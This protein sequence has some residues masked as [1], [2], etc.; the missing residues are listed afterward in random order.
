MTEPSHA[1]FLS[2]ASEDQEATQRICEA[3]RS[4]GIEVWF[5]Q[6][7][8]R[9]G[10]AWDAS[11]RRQIKECA[12]FVPVIS[13]HTDARPV[14]YFR[15]EWHLALDRMM[16]YAED[17][18]FLLPVVIDDTVEATA[19][20]PDRFRERQWTYLKGGAA[21]PEWVERTK[22]LLTERASPARRT[23]V[24]PAV[25]GRS[26]WPRALAALSGAAL[27]ALVATTLW[28]QRMGTMTAA[29][30]A[31]VATAA[32]PA[33]DRKTIAV[34]PFDNL[35]GR[36]EDAYL[37][38]GLQAEVLNTLARLRELS[39]ISRTST[40]EYRDKPL[41]VRDIG[42]R[43]GVGTILEGSIRRY[44]GKLR[45]AVQLVD[46]NSDRQLLAAN[47][48]RDVAHMLDLQ[49]AVARQVADSLLA[50]LSRSDRGELERV[51]TNNGDAYDLYLRAMAGYPLDHTDDDYDVR[52]PKRLLEQ[53][54]KLDPGY[55]DAY[56]FL[57]M[58]NTT[59]YFHRRRPEDAVA[60]RRAFE[61]AFE[62][63]PGLP[64]ARL[65]RG[66]YAT[67][68]ALDP[69]Q[70]LD[71]LQAVVRS[72]PSSARA[73]LQLGL[74]LRRLGRMDEAL[75]HFVR[76]WDLDP[77]HQGGSLRVQPLITLLGLRRWP[78][79][80][81][82]TET[83]LRRFPDEA[84]YYLW[85]A[86]IQSFA[87]HDAEPMR[88]ALRDHGNECDAKERAVTGFEVAI[89]EG[90]YL[91]AIRLQEIGW[92]YFPPVYRE[93]YAGVLYHIAGDERRARDS[94]RAAERHARQDSGAREE[95]AISQS[96]LGEHAAALATID[97]ARARTPESR[98]AINGP[99]IS[100]VRSVVLLRAGRSEEAYAEVNRLLRVPFG[101]PL[102]KFGGL[103][104]VALL[105]KDDTHFDE[106]LH[107]PP[108]L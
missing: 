7:E 67:I 95:L 35:S 40:L 89:A 43:L 92:S 59:S 68:V 12:L 34:L 62:I 36:T 73:H 108:R 58:V 91:D 80:I 17:Q 78:E 85:R 94:L 42:N 86:K 64:E 45:L 28:K 103:N 96:V 69:G 49:S 30:V 16:D 31:K 84:S 81:E 106:L 87:Q 8:L 4:A 107:R 65:A 10:D 97:A 76:S 93:T 21:T 44:G 77:L 3:L 22:R 29:P 19:R 26:R 25:P 101:N 56:A 72:R 9:G 83:L 66:M 32:A 14:G 18:P 100:F 105:V 55:A 48:D 61:R 63:D 15:R 88:A 1:V 41:N 90:R 20:V 70:A 54:V 27:A 33:R 6:S 38:D 98:D 99:E 2:Y 75:G 74:T 5:D 71:D 46:S 47:Y 39:V 82:Q 24:A 13:A 23:A 52:Q 60:A 51:G 79:A 50:T 104:C 11:I 37:A 53:A 102:W 57:S